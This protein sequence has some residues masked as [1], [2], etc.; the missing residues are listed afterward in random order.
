MKKRAFC[1]LLA[2]LLALSGC[3]AMLEQTYTRVEPADER[4]ST[5]EDPS[6][7]EVE[8]RPALTTAILSL[9]RQGVEH[10][11]IRLKNYRGD[12]ES[13][14]SDACL[15]VAQED[16]LGS[17]AVESI[18]HDFSHIISYYEANIYIAYRR[19]HEQVSSL[20]RVTGSSAIRAEIKG[21]LAS[22]SP[23]VLLQVSYFAEDGDY[24]RELVTQAYYESP[25]AA[26]GLPDVA[27]TLYPTETAGYRRVVEI[28]F[29]YAESP[30]TLRKKSAQ[31]VEKTEE[32]CAPL[33]YLTEN[34]AF[35]ALFTALRRQ[36][37]FLPA[38]GEIPRSTAWHALTQGGADSE[39]LALAVEL[40]CRRLELDSMVVSGALEGE[41]HFWNVAR[42]ENGEYRH[43]DVSSPSGC[44]F[45]DAAALER[46]YAWDRESGSIPR[47]GEQPPKPTPEPTPTPE[48]TPPPE[49]ETTPDPELTPGPSG[50][51]AESD[52]PPAETGAE[53]TPPPAETGTEPPPPTG[54]GAEETP[55][56]TETEAESAPPPAESQSPEEGEASP[57][58][59]ES[60]QPT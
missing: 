1:L 35:S 13:D 5:G 44:L 7:I 56:P 31:A 46:G 52:P 26:L 18:K 55:T 34:Q 47:C 8:D 28:Q 59:A 22:F 6:V 2:A 25:A 20:V 29:S 38:D 41:T 4:L 49:G 33:L 24:I 12:V 51:P 50:P 19:T 45:S 43:M 32:L 57:P 23:E 17:Y 21:A 54:T 58:P 14:L 36:A 42:L 9:V 40:L 60:A 11:V 53:E 39:G 16:P 30:E 10:G 3:S 48:L 15:E 27:V 37:A